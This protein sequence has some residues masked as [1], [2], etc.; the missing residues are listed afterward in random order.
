MKSGRTKTLYSSEGCTNGRRLDGQ[1]KCPTSAIVG[2]LRKRLEINVKKKTA[3]VARRPD[4]AI[5][6]FV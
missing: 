5:F 6:I 2:R 4:E 1:D 3:K